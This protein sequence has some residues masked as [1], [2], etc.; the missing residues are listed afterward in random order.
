MLIQETEIQQSHDNEFV[1]ELCKVFEAG[2]DKLQIEP[3]PR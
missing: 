1:E 3:F 2:L